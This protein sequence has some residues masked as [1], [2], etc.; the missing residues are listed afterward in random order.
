M[1]IVYLAGFTRLIRSY[2]R[3][4]LCTWYSILLSF[5]DRVLIVF[6]VTFCDDSFLTVFIKEEEDPLLYM[7]EK[8]L[9]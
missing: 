2:S 4:I 3:F 5:E 8:K 6:L 7:V 1:I 9:F